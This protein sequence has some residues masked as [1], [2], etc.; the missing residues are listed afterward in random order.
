MKIALTGATGF[1]GKLILAE[2]EAVGHS[3]SVL[4]RNPTTVSQQNIKTIKGDLADDTALVRLAAG[5]DVVIHVAGAIT[6]SN[7]AGYFEVNLEGTKRLY[8]AAEKAN[9]RRFVYISSITAREPMLSDY[10]ASKAAAEHFLLGQF[11]GPEIVI[12]RPCAIYGAG[13]KAT[14]PLLKALQSN[15][16]IVPGRATA[17]FSLIHVQDFARVVSAAAISDATGVFEVDD[18]S[19]GHT[20][21]DLA[22]ANRN[23][24]GNPQKVIYAPK[25]LAASFAACAEVL[26]LVTGKPTMTNRGKV[27]ELYHQD[28]VARGANWPRTNALGLSEGY[29]E[30]LQWYIKEGLLPNKPQIDRKQV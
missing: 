19:G 8:A 3:I 23:V 18:L 6:A 5:A 28:W 27:A 1:A 13:D 21:Q 15:L 30:T 12:L 14:L 24:T 11:H 29:F 9:C 25:A 16:A 17:R 10:A 22:D 7:R 4:M 20:W 26:G 2:L